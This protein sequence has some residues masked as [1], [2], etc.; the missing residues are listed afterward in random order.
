MDIKFS[1]SAYTRSHKSNKYL[2]HQNTSAKDISSK[3]LHVLAGLLLRL[4][5]GIILLLLG[6]LLSFSVDIPS[7]CLVILPSL[8]KFFL[9]Y[10]QFLF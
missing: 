5:S 4:L 2:Q 3:V 8:L 6:L 1:C 9:S 7:K 10:R